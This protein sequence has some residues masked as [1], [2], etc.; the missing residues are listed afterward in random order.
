MYARNVLKFTGKILKN[1]G[2]KFTYLLTKIWLD[3]HSSLKKEGAK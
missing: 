1:Y 2:M 3:Y